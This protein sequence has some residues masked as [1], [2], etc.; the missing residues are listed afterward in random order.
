MLFSSVSVL[1]SMFQSY[2]TWFSEIDMHLSKYSKKF[3]ASVMSLDIMSLLLN[4]L[5]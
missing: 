4:Y 3:F 2:F 5:I 1:L